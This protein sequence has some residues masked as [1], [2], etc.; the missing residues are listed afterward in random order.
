MVFALA[1]DSTITSDVVP[2]G[3]DAS[4]SGGST[5]AFRPRVVAALPVARFFAA[6]FALVVFFAVAMEPDE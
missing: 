4:S 2:G 6:V 5:T 3:A 1:G